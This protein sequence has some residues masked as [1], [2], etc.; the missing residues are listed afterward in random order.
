[1]RVLSWA[2]SRGDVLTSSVQNGNDAFVQPCTKRQPPQGATGWQRDVRRRDVRRVPPRERLLLQLLIF[3]PCSSVITRRYIPPGTSFA[4]H[5][6]SMQLD[7]RNFSLPDLFWPERWL[8]ASGKLKS[9]KPRLPRGRGD[10]EYDAAT[11]VHNKAAYIPF[12]YGPMNCIG[13][14]LS[15][16]VIRM[17]VCALL[18]QFKFE[19]TE[20]WD[21]EAWREGIRELGVTRCPPLPVK[22][23]SRV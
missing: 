2:S 12:S 1:M 8:I 10:V 3:I 23:T 15:L 7:P 17:V 11:L 5:A 9:A 19:L 22:V 6:R 13:K 4:C 20:G 18:R 14:E 16:T 21:A